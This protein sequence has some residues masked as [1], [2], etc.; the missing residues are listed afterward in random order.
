[1]Q[2]AAVLWF[3]QALSVRMSSKVAKWDR[4]VHETESHQ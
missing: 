2:H 1:M 4:G 3:K